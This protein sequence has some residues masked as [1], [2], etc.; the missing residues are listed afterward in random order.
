MSPGRKPG[1]S[2]ILIPAMFEIRI[3]LF[4]LA[5][6]YSQDAM[7]CHPKNDRDISNGTG[8]ATVLRQGLTP[9]TAEVLSLQPFRPVATISAIPLQRD[10]KTQGFALSQAFCAPQHGKPSRHPFRRGHLAL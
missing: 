3:S 2:F 9:R 6:E 7:V 4:D 10:Q 8:D 5:V 1:L